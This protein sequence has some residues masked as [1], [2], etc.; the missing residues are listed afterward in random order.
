MVYVRVCPSNLFLL[1]IVSNV[2][3]GSGKTII[4]FVSLQLYYTRRINVFD[5]SSIIEELEGIC[6]AGLDTIA[7]F[8]CNFRDA[9][10][11]NARNLLSSILTQFCHRSEAFSNILSSLYSVH[12]DGSREPSIDALLGCLKT[13]LAL[14]GQG[15]LY[16][17]VDALDECPNSSGLPTQRE[18]VLKIVKELID[19]KL[20]H[21]RFCVSSRPEI[22]I[23]KVFE[24]LGP[25]NVSLHDHRGQIEDLGKYVEE[26]VRSDEAMRD[27][28]EVIKK[29]V[30]NT[31]AEKGGGM[32]VMMFM[33][34]RI[35]SS[36]DG[37]RFRWAYCQLET[38]RRCPLRNISRVLE[39]LPET[40]DD[41]YERILLAIPQAKREDANRIFQCLLI[42]SRP[43]HVEEL[44]EVFTFD[45]DAETSGIP[46]FDP[47]LRPS[48]AEASVLSACSTLV[49]VVK[50]THARDKGKKMVQFAHFSVKEY[51]TSDRI[52][53]SALVSHFHVLP[54][55]AHTLLAKACLGVLLQLDHSIDKTKILDFP[56]A[57]YAAKHWVDHA[58]FEDVSSDIQDGMDCLFDKDKPHFAAWIWT[59]D[60][61]DCR[62][63]NH[64]RKYKSTFRPEQPDADPLYY[65]ALSGFRD[66]A[67]RLMEAHLMDVH[68]QAGHHGGPL[69]AALHG[70]HLDIALSL[71]ECGADVE[72]RCCEGQ[73]ALYRASSRGYAEVVQL[74]I[75][76]GADLDAEYDH[77]DDG[78]KAKLTPLLVAL[79]NGRLE[80]A[81]ML[82]ESG[83]N[84][85]ARGGYQRYPQTSLYR[86]SCRGDTE[87]VRWLIGRGADPN[88]QCGDLDNDGDEVEFT[89][90]LVASRFDSLEVASVLLEE[91]VDVDYQDKYGRSSLHYASGNDRRTDDLARLLLAY[92]ANPNISDKWNKTALHHASSG[93]QVTLVALL[94]E[95]GAKVDTRDDKRGTSLHRATSNGHSKV[96][97]L[98][99]DHGADVNAQANDRRT[100]LHIAAD[101]G[102]F[103]VVEVLLERG[104]DVNAQAN[105]RLTALHMAAGS[106]KFQVVKI[107]LE[108][109][110]DPLART[111]KGETPFELAG[112]NHLYPWMHD[113]SQ[114]R[115]LLSECTDER[116]EDVDAGLVQA[117][118]EFRMRL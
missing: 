35:V 95:Y 6:Q 47:S 118:C 31:L 99:L 82:L 10:K 64:P 83:A 74:L 61:D 46:T 1:L 55:P 48:N 100:A 84:I 29:L 78:F 116:M 73:P 70:E 68:S 86:A 43:L 106:G 92:G 80:I 28:P 79:D 89:P 114:V 22:D 53:N 97:Q 50:A 103:Q 57:Q 8:Y 21:F 104:A 59:N 34:F 108:R 117:N 17:V 81:R 93:G 101:A 65:A 56:L 13:M 102:N 45:F 94:L 110:A 42:S 112:M 44:A 33:M 105:D 3:A 30:I 26:V 111:D 38:L 7:I 9:K 14:P 88:A 41:T 37:S 52:V 11:Q 24:P 75:D 76:R 51:L 72:S 60:I 69:N 27:W 5:S 67:E 77:W 36:C 91:Y 2:L 54:K 58:H 87:A 62:H 40:L 66:L 71:L 4:S 96:V 18:Q 98:L 85:E 113:T 19:L 32:Y 16:I 107:L 63:C 12:R 15:T 25:Y 49:S 20:P 115:R 23:R 109:G 90:L 39:E